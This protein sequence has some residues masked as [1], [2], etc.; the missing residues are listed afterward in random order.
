MRERPPNLFVPA[1]CLLGCK[2]DLHE[3]TM[4]RR[5]WIADQWDE[6][7]ATLTGAQAEHLARVLRARVGQEFDIVAGGV[8]RR[9]TVEAIHP[10]TVLFQL[11]EAIESA[12]SLP[13]T[14]ALSIFKFDRYEWAIEK[15]TEL[16]IATIV[17]VIARRT[18]KHLAQ[19]AEARVERWRRIAREAAQQSRRTDV[20][21]IADP[22]ALEKMNLPTQGAWNLLLSEVEEET[23]LWAALTN[24]METRAAL[25]AVHMAIGPVG[26]WTEP[27][28]QWFV[29][30]QWRPV[31]LGSRILRAE[32]AAIATA[33]ILAAW[34]EEAHLQS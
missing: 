19:A 17:P 34:L 16:G 3:R 24:N 26:G 11:W 20:P 30:Q 29:R 10:N 27:E 33:S 32:T 9:G 1:A 5:R 6:T 13:L 18:E 7:S 8:V 2:R 23:T 22:I 14:C 12:A 15:L 31:S 4:T 21:A 25:S 28:M